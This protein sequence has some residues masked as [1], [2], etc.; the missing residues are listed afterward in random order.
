MLKT[1]ILTAICVLLLFLVA[2]FYLSS[3]F[4]MTLL[5]ILAVIGSWEWSRLAK[6][7]LS[8]SIFYLVLTVLIGGEL[9]FILSRAVLTN[10]YT[11]VF[12]PLYAATLVF[13]I[14]GA[15]SLLKLNLPI[16]NP[17][18]FALIGWL[19]LLPTCLS[20]YQLRAIDPLLL[21]GFMTAIW[22][23]DTSAY[24][25]GRTFGRH[26]LAP[27]VS[28]GKTWEGVVGALIAVS[29]YA[30]T[31]GYLAEGKIHIILLVL[32]L[33]VL[34]VLGIIGDLFESLIKRQAGVKNSGNIL[35]GHGGILDRI[36]ALTSTLPIAVLAVL[37]FNIEL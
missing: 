2:L 18:L 28:P 29:I 1:R 14:L 9:L 8:G 22:V 3:I 16:R 20:L 11:T 21:L 5:L 19:L 25:V 37:L 30:L 26:K 24:F 33:L 32:L 23:S 36:D 17:A 13:W 27:K 35:P 31:W 12:L 6:F 7:S 15:P 10:S 34:A 4:W